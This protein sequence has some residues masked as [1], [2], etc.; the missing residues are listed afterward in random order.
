M[1]RTS[2]VLALALVLVGTGFALVGPEL[3]AQI[4]VAGQDHQV[5]VII[6]LHEQFD[7]GQLGALV[8]GMPKRLR[9]AEVARILSDFSE[10]QQAGL[11]ELL[12]R[13]EAEGAVSGTGSLWLVNAA[14]CRATEAAIRA[15]EQH[16][17][18]WYVDADVKHVPGLLPAAAVGDA[19]DGGE[20]IDWG[21]QKVNAPAVW[22][23]GYTGQGI[24]V[25][26][27]DTGCNYNHLD[28]ADHMWTDANYPNHGWNFENNTNDPMDSNGHGTHTC[29]SVASDGTAGSQCGVA[30]DANIMSCRVRTVADSLAETQV[31][32][33][34]QF[35]VSP[36][37]SPTNGGDLI[38]MSL[39]WINGW[40]PMRKLWRD[41]C[42]NVG[43]AGVIMCVAAGNERSSSPP[44]STRTPGDVPPPWW[45]PQNV[46]TGALS[47]VISCGATDSNDN[48]ASFSSRGPSEWGTVAGY[49]DYPHPPGLTRP[50]VAAPGVN[51]KSC[52]RSSNNG[53]TTMSGTSMATPH[54]AGVV[55]LMLSKNPNL[56]AA[57]V[58]SI[59]EITAVDRGPTGKDMDYGAGRIDALE[60]I[61][62]ITGSGGPMLTLQGTT[63]YDPGGNNNGRV[64]PGE[65]AQLEMSLRNTGGAACNNTA[66]TL[67]SGDVRLVVSDANGTWGNIPSGESRTNSSDRFEVQANSSIPPGTSIP[68]T[69][70]VSGDSADYTNT[71]VFNLTVGE[72]PTPG[73]LLMTH[74]T[75]YC[76]LTVSCFGPIGYDL[77]PADLGSGFCYPKASASALFYSSFAMGNSQSY[78]A[79]R[80]FSQPASG[81]PNQDLR[82]VD[83]L[84][85][86]NPPQA[87]SEQFRGKFNDAGHPSAKSISVTQNSYQDVRTGYDDFV[88]LVYD[89]ENNGSS[90][91]SGMY[92][93]VF[94]DFDIGSTPT[95]N[96]AGSDESRRFTW[97]RQS[98]SANPTV[99]VKIL[100]PNS[101]A[102]LSAVDHAR[103]VYPDSCMTDG[104]KWRFLDGTVA[105]RSSNRAYDWSI[106]TSAGPFDLAVGQTYRFAVAFVGGTSESEALAHAD[107]AQSWFDGNV[108]I[109][110]R[111]GQ[112]PAARL[113]D[114]LPNPFSGRARIS[115][116]ATRAGRVKITAF[117]VS[118]RNAWTVFD[119]DVN[120]GRGEVTWQPSELAGGVYFV[121]LEG[122]DGLVTERALLA[123]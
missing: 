11:M 5:P 28:L 25:G 65:T 57:V 98:S 81:T 52:S 45:N 105:Q 104:Q 31:W 73:Q 79:D 56:S 59:L 77:P 106:L 1:K 122:P 96:T 20:E 34:M 118:G 24:V 115:Y 3:E 39:G 89:I 40:D 67:A 95:S 111:P 30:P 90:A 112:E 102:N 86:V 80:H 8:D 87:G 12:G 41:G 19:T 47:N 33:A 43:A 17:D 18:V 16:P 64:D 35:V 114:V 53:Y 22:A 49:N 109:V 50:D 117:D 37:L 51:I 85:P 54:T 101:F 88:V 92:A 70:H 58:D 68:C 42:N 120:A 9:Q 36:P 93:G 94:A 7:A 32:A 62:H 100:A 103:Y 72:P 29:G 75:G 21:V 48:Y 2:V 121:R 91:V 116:Q 61:N 108:G 69:L 46:G 83:S 23:L 97:M 10:Q 44:Y 74:D 14:Y 113:L 84:R 13:L 82:V 123:R 26:D 38:T 66:G 76:K 60:A 55:A 27:I 63:V 99:G 4:S 6:A 119:G 107:S 78:V 71:F 110:E 15:I